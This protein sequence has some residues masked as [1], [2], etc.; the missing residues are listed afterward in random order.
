[1]SGQ[2]NPG[3]GNGCLKL[4]LIS[5]LVLGT[6]LLF[7]TAGEGQGAGVKRRGFLYMILLPGAYVAWSHFQ[8][9]DPKE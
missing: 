7:K 1:M 2:T 6:A 8:K 5:F 3:F 9:A 4:V